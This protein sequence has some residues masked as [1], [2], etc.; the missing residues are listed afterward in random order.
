MMNKMFREWLKTEMHLSDEDM[1]NESLLGELFEGTIGRF[2]APEDMLEWVFLQGARTCV[3]ACIQSVEFAD[4]TD[5]AYSG[6][7]NI[8]DE[9]ERA[10]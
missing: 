8:S 2:R 6:L 4:S 7:L 10:I 1:A 5:D 9:L 3:G